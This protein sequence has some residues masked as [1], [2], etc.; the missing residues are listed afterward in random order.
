M[1]MLHTECL[2]PSRAHATAIA[3]ADIGLT[4]SYG[5]LATA[6]R[7]LAAAIAR[8][9]PAGG[10]R[11]AV[12]L[13]S[14]IEFCVVTFALL[15]RGI[16]IAP[17]D[18]SLRGLSLDTA[19]R[20]LSPHVVVAAPSVMARV[21][22]D[23]LAECSLKLNLE[24]VHA[25]RS[26][27]LVVEL[28]SDLG[29]DRRMIAVQQDDG[30]P[31]PRERATRNPDADA[32]LVSTSGSTGL[33]KYVRLG[34]AGTLFNARGHLKALGLTAPFRAFQALDVS[35]SYG[36]VA[37]MLATFVAGGT[38]CLPVRSDLQALRPALIR[39]GARVCLGS[40]ALFDYM[41]QTCPADERDGLR[42]LTVIGIGGDRATETLRRRI[43]AALPQ[44]AAHVTYGVTEAGPRVATL[45]P[46]RLLTAP[47]SVGFPLDGV[48]IAILDE[49]GEP[50]PAGQVGLLHIRTP[51]RMNGYLDDPTPLD[52]SGWLAVKDLASLDPEGMLVIHGRADRQFKHRGRRINPA[53]IERVIERLP[54]VV[55]VRVEPVP[56]SDSLRAIVH[57][58]IDVGDDFCDRLVAHCRRNLPP[59]LVPEIVETV[60]ETSGFF[61][62]GRPLAVPGTVG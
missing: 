47:D 40:P 9:L 51:S 54:K 22:R 19:L 20:R 50:M 29:S 30:M 10:G 18:V 26:P 38:L 7:R 23:R 44:V 59:R 25:E 1:S 52:P 45:P 49:D 12:L 31:E 62:K 58:Q 42:A 14:S 33:P 34:H 16:A 4:I 5:A 37:S 11:A 24:C 36:L 17:I 61:F 57:H 46:D 21:P 39:S 6:A 56:G 60:P 35:Y 3:V 43:A 8:H 28:A 32:L 2:S 53:Q 13:P 55:S 41:L 48:E 15:E 27:V